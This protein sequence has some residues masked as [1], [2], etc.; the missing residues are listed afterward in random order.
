MLY[1]SRENDGRPSSSVDDW[2]NTKGD[3]ASRE[4]NSSSMLFEDG[5]NG[6]IGFFVFIT[7]GSIGAKTKNATQGVVVKLSQLRASERPQDK[8]YNGLYSGKMFGTC[9]IFTHV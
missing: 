8:P 5:M 6:H 7:P 9:Y 4:T 2:A 1:L 3:T